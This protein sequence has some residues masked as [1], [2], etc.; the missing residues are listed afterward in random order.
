MFFI[1]FLKDNASDP[2][3]YIVLI[4]VGVFIYAFISIYINNRR[5]NNIKRNSIETIATIIS[6]RSMP[7]ENSAYVNVE[8]KVAY[9]DNEGKR[10]LSIGNSVIDVTDLQKYQP[11]NELPI[12]Y[13]K[14]QFDKFYINIVNPMQ[15][16]TLKINN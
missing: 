7:G 6:I 10:H 9:Q 5:K 8:F 1:K 13:I 14:G 15:S 2:F 12:K 3:F 16:R 4:V 11:G